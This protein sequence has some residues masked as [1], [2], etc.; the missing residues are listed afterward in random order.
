M[1]SSEVLITGMRYLEMTNRE[2]ITANIRYLLLRH[3]YKQLSTD[4]VYDRICTLTT[5]QWLLA[6]NGRLDNE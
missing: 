5:E 1:I 6:S 2:R 3:Q 4:Y